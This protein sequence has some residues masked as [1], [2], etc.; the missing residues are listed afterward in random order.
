MNEVVINL[1]TRSYRVAIEPGL[2]RETG[3]RVMSLF[4]GARR[5][6]VVGDRRVLGL[7]GRPLRASLERARLRAT[8]IAVRG[9]EREKTLAGATRLYGRLLQAG[10]DRE[11]PLL[12][13]GG[14]VIGDLA[15]FVAAT[16]MRGIPY[17]QV[18]TTLLAQVDA[19]VGGKTGVN[20]PA[21]KNLI[22]AFHQP[23]AVLIDPAV[24]ATLPHR[25]LSSGL[26][27]CVKAGMIRSLDYFQFLE[28][29]ADAILG[30][31][32]FA[33]VETIST[34]VSL[35]ADI[36]EQDERESR[37]R[38]ILNYGHTVGHAIEAATGYR[39]YTHG[40]AVSIGMTVAG[41][42]ALARGRIGEAQLA[43]QTALLLR[44]GLPVRH[45]LDPAQLLRIARHDKKNRAGG[46]TFVLPRGIGHATAESGV[47]PEEVRAA[48]RLW[49]T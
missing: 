44:L 24:L 33:I 49:R 3:D 19:S 35:K 5:V 47:R 12:A 8:V 9:G 46:L 31:Q 34:A 48:L 28:R 26:A 39:R 2:L 38:M 41:Q 7:H 10:A 18:P 16:Y 37:L 14:G 13:F 17:V 4:P 27:E 21:A 43:R 20:H 1:G 23:A 29:N 22:G 36:V 25:E 11:T 6:I 30:M 45:D 32:A 42:I 40:E 15:G